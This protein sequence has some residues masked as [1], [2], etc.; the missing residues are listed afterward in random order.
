LELIESRTSIFLYRSDDFDTGG[1]EMSEVRRKEGSISVAILVLLTSSLIISTSLSASAKAHNSLMG[2]D[3]DFAEYGTLTSVSG[4]EL[5]AL[6]CPIPEA[7]IY[8]TM[9]EFQGY[10]YIGSASASHHSYIY[11]YDPTT[12]ECMKWKDAGVYFVYSSG[13]YGGVAFWGNRGTRYA[14]T[15]PLLYFDGTTFGTI[16][17]N[18]W[19]SSTGL[20][21]WVEDFEVFNDRLY[22]SGTICTSTPENSNYFFVKYCD[23]APCLSASDWHWTDTSRGNIGRIDDGTELEEFNGDLYLAT[24]DTASVLRYYTSNNTWWHSLSGAVDGD[25][26][27]MRG[28]YGIFGLVSYGGYLHAFTYHYG[29]HWK[30]QDGISWNYV[31]LPYEI[32]TRAFVFE[33]RIYL[34][35]SDNSG[36]YVITYDGSSWSVFVVG[37][38]HFR[39]FSVYGN[40]L[41][42][43]AGNQVY[44]AGGSAHAEATMDCDP[45]TLNLK[46]GGGWITV[47]LMTEGAKAEDIDA[48]SLLLNDVVGPEW[49]NTQDDVTLMVKF[50]RATVQSIL[51]VSDSVDIKI[52][53]QWT[54]GESFEVHDTIR[55][56]DSGQ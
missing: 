6:P 56:F 15:G 34:G 45:D 38:T 30:T 43:T 32:L 53:G 47:Y 23:N 27:G 1:V 14:T 28:G 2:E 44:Q 19:F 9:L 46:S 3:S 52:T 24:Y 22:A 51:T 48:S 31:D 26:A 7:D 12:D 42:T 40:M 17:G 25:T 49:G 41:W 16:P 8:T 36:H 35:A 4:D 11:R 21:G 18:V 29:W 13:K 54:D 39:Y 33:D 20:S 10:L 37:S 5:P 50:D 55:V